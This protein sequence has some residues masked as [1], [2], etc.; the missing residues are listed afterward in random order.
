MIYYKVKECFFK[1][2]KRPKRK[3]LSSTMYHQIWFQDYGSSPDG[4]GGVIDGWV[5]K[6]QTWASI[7]P[8]K[9]SQKDDY[10]SISTEV[11]HTIKIRG[12]VNC[13]D[14]Q[15]IRYGE[16][17]FEILTVENILEKDTMKIVTCKEVSR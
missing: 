3:Y 12:N 13:N 17:H 5:D 9:A 8:I 15:R 1:M 11:T 10:Q 14:E 16:R 7:N 6:T 4:E 2:Y